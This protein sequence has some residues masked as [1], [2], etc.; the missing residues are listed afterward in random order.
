MSNCWKLQV[1]V[2]KN[3]T[4]IVYTCMIVLLSSKVLV[5]FLCSI[6]WRFV[7]LTSES[8]SE[9]IGVARDFAQL[10]DNECAEIVDTIK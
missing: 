1:E 2:F 7:N 8:L 4:R 5:H 10:L 3:Q 6:F 9:Q